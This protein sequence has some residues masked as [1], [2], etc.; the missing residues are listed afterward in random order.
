[1]THPL[2]L[3]FRASSWSL[4]AARG[5]L[6]ERAREEAEVIAAEQAEGATDG[7][8]STAYGQRS[9]P[10][11]HGD[12]VSAVALDGIRPPRPNRYQQLANSVTAT[13]V[14]LADTIN[15]EDAGDPLTRLNHARLRPGTAATVTRWLD[16]ADRRIRD[17]IGLAPHLW[18]LP[19]NPECPSCRM[20]S[21]FVQTAAPSDRWTVI[22]R[23][24]CVCAG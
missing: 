9:G 10:G 17:S 18:A 12:P 21:L 22:C 1:M 4:N 11:G 23:A 7:L 24:S 6:H 16:D 2:L 13:L 14:W 3:H 5:A 19:G 15:A 20:V 8:K